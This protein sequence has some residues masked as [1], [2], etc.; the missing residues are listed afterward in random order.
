MIRYILIAILS[1]MTACASAA[2]QIS[3]QR[4]RISAQDA[5]REAR[6]VAAGW[7]PGAQLRYLEGEGITP[8]G[9]V[10]PGRGAWRF[11][12]EAENRADQLVVTVTPR[13]LEDAV[14]PRQGPAGV[15]IGGGSLPDGWIDSPRV[16]AA[17][18]AAGGAELLDAGEPAISL[19]LAPLRPPEWVVRVAVGSTSREWRVDAGR[20]E[21][22]GG[23]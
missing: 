17:V 18:R 9:Y 4:L 10:L 13:R 23:G 14:R 20:G 19:L 7:A 11:I 5:A 2:S 12:Y 8:E 1:G 21:V 6:T 15:S 22:V 3:P 16:L